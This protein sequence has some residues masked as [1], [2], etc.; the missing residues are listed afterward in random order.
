MKQF[1][2]ENGLTQ[3]YTGKGKGKTTAAFGL[4]WRML[5]YGGKVY[6]CQFLKPEEID[7]GEAFT[8]H[9][10]QEIFPGLLDYC[11]SDYKWNM[12]TWDDPAQRQI[13]GE[14]IYARLAEIEKLLPSGEYDLVVLDE[15]VVCYDMGLITIEDIKKLIDIK[16]PGTELVMTGRGGDEKLYDL[17]DLVTEM[18]EIKHPFNAGIPAR[19]AIEF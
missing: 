14:K 2:L 8:A 18:T 7:T 12:G 3:V 9:K 5:G 13:A 1:N 6:F 16:H 10:M 4:T 19:K 17:V 11:R 15:L